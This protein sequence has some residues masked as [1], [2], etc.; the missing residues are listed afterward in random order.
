[1]PEYVYQAHEIED[2]MNEKAGTR[3]LDDDDIADDVVEISSDDDDDDDAPPKPLP[4]AP[5]KTKK[6]PVDNTG[7][8]ARRAASDRI[9]QPRQPRNM[10]ANLLSTL[11]G[12]LDPAAQAARQ[13][14]R[15][16]RTFQTSQLFALTAQLRESQNLVESLRTRLAESDRDRNAAERR[17]DKA[18]MMAM[19]SGRQAPQP[20]SNPPR[21]ANLPSANRTPSRPVRHDV[22]YSDGGRG[23]RWVGPDDSPQLYPDSPGTRYFARYT[24]ERVEFTSRSVQMD[25]SP[26]ATRSS[27]RPLAPS[28]HSR[29]SSSRHQQ[30]P[31]PMPMSLP[32]SSIPSS[33]RH[34]MCIP[35]AL[36]DMP[37]SNASGH[38]ADVFTDAQ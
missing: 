12:A 31:V 34:P 20:P 3:D 21:W 9:S 17:A 15:A 38:D 27:S 6:E 19:F 10:G 33:S 2:A 28:F 36:S 23:V 26:T 1:M 14:E 22:Y 7:P 13:E 18:E 16:A 8:I 24:P 37:I 29:E 35:E 32:S 30:S 11:S 4:S 25:H 5:K